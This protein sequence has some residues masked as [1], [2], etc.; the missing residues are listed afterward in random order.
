MACT[1]AVILNYFTVV[2]TF[3]VSVVHPNAYADSGIMCWYNAGK[4]GYNA[5]IR[6]RSHMTSARFWQI[7]PLPPVSNCQH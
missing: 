4:R 3:I 1:L 5:G 7:F 2:N 6:E